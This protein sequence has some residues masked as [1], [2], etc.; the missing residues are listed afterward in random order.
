MKAEDVKTAVA[1]LNQLETLRLVPDELRRFGDHGIDRWPA[2]NEGSPIRLGLSFPRFLIEKAID[3][4]IERLS[5]M[6]TEL[7]VEGFQ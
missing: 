3:G 4:E 5:L 7:G 6:L 2:R 1:L